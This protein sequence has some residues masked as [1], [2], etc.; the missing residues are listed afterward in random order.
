MGK[1]VRQRGCVVAISLL[2]SAHAPP[3][4]HASPACPACLAF[5]ASPA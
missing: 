5:P 3:A 2:A 1:G 4:Y